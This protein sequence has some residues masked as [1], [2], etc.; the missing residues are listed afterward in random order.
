MGPGSDRDPPRVHEYLEHGWD[1]QPINHIYYWSLKGIK[2]YVGNGPQGE[3]KFSKT[4]MHIYR[5]VPIISQD[6]M[7]LS[8]KS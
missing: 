6:M 4:V 8:I 7:C 2:R 1:P 5:T 3:I